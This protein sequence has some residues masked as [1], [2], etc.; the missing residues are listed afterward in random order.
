MS[1]LGVDWTNLRKR[2]PE[3]IPEV[4]NVDDIGNFQK[5]KEFLEEEKNNPLFN[6]KARNVFNKRKLYIIIK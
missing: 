5:K 4:R 2:V 1:F 3:Y 6:K